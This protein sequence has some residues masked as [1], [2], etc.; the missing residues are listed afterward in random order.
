MKKL[1]LFV[2]GVVLG[3]AISVPAI[4]ISRNPDTLLGKL[5]TTILPLP[6]PESEEAGFFS[7]Y[8]P[9]KQ[10]EGFEEW[11]VRDF[12][13]DKRGGVF[14]DVGAAEYKT[15]SNTWFLEY[16]LGWS[17][18]AVDAQDHYR[19]DWERYRPQSKFF[20]FFVSDHS[21]DQTRLFLSKNAPSVASFQQR[22]TEQ[23]GGVLGG[24]VDVPT[25]TL[26]DLL[27][28]LHVNAF[29]FLSMD[30]ELA[31]PQALA[32]LDL[33]RFK[34]A[35]VCVEAHHQ[36]RQQILDYFAAHHYSIVGKYLRVD[37]M[38]LWFVPAAGTS[39]ESFSLQPATS[40]YGFPGAVLQTSQT[41]RFVLS[42][43]A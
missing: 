8:G 29:D 5:R 31:E 22:F 41:L 28:G 33:Q 10:S 26:N 24:S 34:P 6:Q 25:I 17:G 42:P 37:R 27:A 12:F 23:W 2:L 43:I 40:P 36:V 21:N 11:I 39:V 32:G 13:Q 20:T 7:R 4:R 3:A 14:V 18:V 19:R 38:N 30:I 16:E 35:L 9:T 1:G 15:G